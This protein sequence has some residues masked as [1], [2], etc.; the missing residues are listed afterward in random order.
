MRLLAD[1]MA[2]EAMQ[3]ADL[4]TQGFGA[5]NY[6]CKCAETRVVAKTR[7]ENL[8]GQTGVSPPVLPVRASK[9][10]FAFWAFFGQPFLIN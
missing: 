4:F 6:V 7:H 3:S 10:F 5:D 8:Q 1:G 9:G 2:P